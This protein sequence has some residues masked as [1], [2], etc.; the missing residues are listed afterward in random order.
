MKLDKEKDF[1]KEYKH[2][3]EIE[4]KNW[5]ENQQKIKAFTQKLQDEIKE[6]KVSTTWMK[7]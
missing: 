7:S 2:N 3:I 6:F 5:A 1:Q 4:K